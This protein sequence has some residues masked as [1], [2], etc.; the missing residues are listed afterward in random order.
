MNE[1]TF[2]I[3]KSIKAQEKYCNENGY[4]YF[5]PSDGVCWRCHRN[6]YQPIEHK[7][8]QDGSYYTGISTE[9]AGSFLITSCPHCN[10]SFCD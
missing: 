5:T 3:Q 2:D 1:K 7:S 8:D 9:S 6:I 10:K 4:P